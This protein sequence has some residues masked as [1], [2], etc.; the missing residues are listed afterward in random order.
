MNIDFRY[1]PATISLIA[2]NVAVFAILGILGLL[3]D[4]RLYNTGV[5][6]VGGLVA[7][8]Y[9]ALITSMFLH[10]GILHLLC[11]MITLLYVGSIIEEVFGTIRFLA[12][13]F[14]SGIAGGITFALVH[15]LQGNVMTGAVGASGAIFGLF[16]AYAYLMVR[17][18]RSACVLMRAPS[19]DD[20]KGIGALVGL[21]I[22]I[23]L[24]PGIA[25][26]AH[27][28][29]LV[30][31]AIAT[32]PFYAALRHRV[33]R[34]IEEG[35]APAPIM[36]PVSPPYDFQAAQAAQDAAM[37]A[38]Q[39][40]ERKWHETKPAQRESLERAARHENDPHE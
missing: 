14:L 27:L 30:M 8:R 28:G 16:G 6:T 13:Y 34:A 9:Y 33:K 5:L 17:E 2:I 24:A 26:E 11:N 36:E 31:G 29:G 40:F 19:A 4:Y 12:V 37:K 21:N 3:Q 25:M 22:I 10:G 35:L 23:G 15:L 32:V 1:H 39:S 38:Q 20:L 7:G 18:H